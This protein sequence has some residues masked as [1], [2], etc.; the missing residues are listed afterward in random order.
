MIFHFRD[1][2]TEMVKKFAFFTLLVLEIMIL[3]GKV[4]EGGDEDEDEDERA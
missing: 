1:Q 3:R 2:K 4:G